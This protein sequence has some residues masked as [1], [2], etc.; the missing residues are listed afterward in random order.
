MDTENGKISEKKTDLSDKD[1][2]EQACSYFY[3]HAGQRT[4]MINYFIAV[5]GA[6][7]AVYGALITKPENSIACA[8][9]AIFMGLVSWIFYLID[10]RNK[11]DVKKSENVIRQFERDYGVDS[12]KNDY[13][14]GVFSNETNIFK[15]Y[16]D[17]KSLKYKKEYKDLL[18]LRKQVAKGH[19]DPELLDKK[20]RE[21]VA[22]DKTVSFHE[23]CE[24][25]EENPVAHLSSCIKWLYYLCIA[26]S[27]A[28]FIY[29]AINIVNTFLS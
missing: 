25:L 17:R 12:P 9:I 6:F 23:V 26:S 21:L 13:A 27:I 2:Y 22:E 18:K 14:Y 20:I 19:A 3:Y 10:L 16:G 1:F 11:F 28:A 15:Y 8:L 29:A 24:S 7:L 4:T 5:F